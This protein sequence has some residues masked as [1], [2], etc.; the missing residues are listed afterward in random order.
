MQI[1]IK[2]SSRSHQP[3]C[4]GKAMATYRYIE[5]KNA[6]CQNPIKLSCTF[7]VFLIPSVLISMIFVSKQKLS[8]LKLCF[9]HTP[10][11]LWC[12][13]IV[14]DDTK[15]FKQYELRCYKYWKVCSSLKELA[16]HTEVSRDIG[17]VKGGVYNP[18]GESTAQNKSFQYKRKKNKPNQWKET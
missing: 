6:F 11:S 10:I 3:P 12:Q 15:C 7:S 17:I 8:P 14:H 4:H 2:A 5:K 9:P 16:A 1:G 13:N 18:S